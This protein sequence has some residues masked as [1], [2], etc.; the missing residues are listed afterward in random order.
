MDYIVLFSTVGVGHHVLAVRLHYIY[1]IF[2]GSYSLLT[3]FISRVYKN[4]TVTTVHKNI[5]I[6][7]LN[8]RFN[9]KKSAKPR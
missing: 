6:H 9:C 4:L 1:L 5:R 7:M 2:T 3:I 8:I